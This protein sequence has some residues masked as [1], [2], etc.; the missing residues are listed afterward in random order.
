MVAHGKVYDVTAFLEDHP[1]G[2]YSI[3]RHA[4]QDATEDFDFH[5]RSAQK[6]W[7]EY[8]IGKVESDGKPG[9]L[10]M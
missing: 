5:S 1:A 3:L 9:C 7:K 2:A 8:I 10:L 4:G 6:K